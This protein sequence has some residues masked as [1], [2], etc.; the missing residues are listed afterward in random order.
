MADELETQN[1][2]DITLEP[3]EESEN[4]K[5]PAEKVKQLKEQL[6]ACQK[7]RQEYLGGWQRARAD[8]ANSK[9]DEERARERLVQFANEGL[10]EELLPALDSFHTAFGN[11]EAWEK[12]DLNWRMGVQHIYMQLRSVLERHGISFIEPKAG[13]PFDPKA[14][15]SIEAVPVSEKEKDHA[16]LE[17]VQKGFRLHGKILQPAKVK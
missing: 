16:V 11:K 8:Y 10:I 5:D 3:S 4:L 13:E 2:D 1:Q 6:K 7:E 14:H 17:V 12:I 15:A 9:K